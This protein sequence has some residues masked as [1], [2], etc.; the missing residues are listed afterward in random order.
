MLEEIQLGLWLRPAGG[1][2]GQVLHEIEALLGST[3]LHYRI[4]TEVGRT[5][6]TTAAFGAK[7]GAPALATAIEAE[8]AQ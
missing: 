4:A 8:P 5:D 3:V 7:L 6:E 2:T 1:G